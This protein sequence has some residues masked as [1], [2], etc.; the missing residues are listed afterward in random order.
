M[1]LSLKGKRALVSGSSQGIGKACAMEL[2]KLGASVVLLARREEALQE[3]L[4]QLDNKQRQQHEYIVADFSNIA[5]LKEKVDA[6]IIRNGAIQ[7]LVNNTGGPPP[8]AAINAKQEE[9]QIA[10]NNH[11]IGNHILVQALVDGMKKSGYGRIVNMISTSVKQP[12]KGLGVSNTI[13]GAVANWAKTLSVELAPWNIT[14]NNV[15][16]G[17][18]A[19]E[20]LSSIIENK[21]NKSGSSIAE[22]EAEMLAEI[23]LMRFAQP[24]EIAFAVAFLASP[25][26]AYITGI[27]M[28]V[29]GGRTG[30]L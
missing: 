5:Q 26:A 7:I 22:A 9:F 23:P 30:C 29:D 25:S 24:E 3:V 28:P 12:L 21:S 20:R 6:F 17:A 27:N 11:L 8:G 16:P 4:Q 1:E 15:L 18:T 13:R 19:T 2:A 14:V 10:F